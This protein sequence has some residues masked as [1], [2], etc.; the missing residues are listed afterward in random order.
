MPGQEEEA[1]GNGH[2]GTAKPG[3]V[4]ATDPTTQQTA[5]NGGG[6]GN[7]GGFSKGQGGN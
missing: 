5:A 3:K 1:P 6:K 4:T 2:Q 7:G